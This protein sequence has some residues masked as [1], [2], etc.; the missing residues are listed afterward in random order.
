VNAAEII[1]ATAKDAFIAGHLAAIVA[2]DPLYS[3]IAKQ[4][5]VRVLA[6]V[7]AAFSN[8]SVYWGRQ[9]VLRDHPDA[10]R[11]LLDALILS[12]H[13]TQAD[14]AEAAALLAGLNGNSA[15]AWLPALTGRPW[16]VEPPDAGFLAEQ[17]AHADLFA[18]FGLIPRVLD[19][20]DTID[21]SHLPMI[22]A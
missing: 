9:E 21:A 17:Q 1:P 7:G 5:P 11:A 16:G 6:R 20:T 22:A 3:Q 19:V 13:A 15:A 18:K 8:R 12:D 4:V 14:P 10:V 2:T